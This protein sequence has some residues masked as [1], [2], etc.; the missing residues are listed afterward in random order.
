[1]RTATWL[2]ALAL[3]VVAGAPLTACS[4][5]PERQ[6]CGVLEADGDDYLEVDPAACPAPEAVVSPAG[7]RWVPVSA[8]DDDDHDHHRTVVA[9][10]PGTPRT[11]AART[12]AP[13]ATAAPRTTTKTTGP[14]RTTRSR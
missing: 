8:L 12:P 5:G 2:S 10:S 6:V 7:P 11:T 14:K 13:R 1:M 3:V 9:R 4:T